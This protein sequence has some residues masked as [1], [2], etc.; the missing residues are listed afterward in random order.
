M[1]SIVNPNY[2]YDRL[3][4]DIDTA[5][6]K[7]DHGQDETVHMDGNTICEEQELKEHEKD[8]EEGKDDQAAIERNEVNNKGNSK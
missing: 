4:K 6:F 8:M 5:K 3:L 7:K 1:S 2:D